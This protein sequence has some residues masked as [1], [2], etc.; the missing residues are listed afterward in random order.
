MEQ[1]KTQ[2]LNKAIHILLAEDEEL[3]R[4][5]A[6]QFFKIM[7]YNFTICKNGAEALEI[8]RKSWQNIDLVF[9][10]MIM[11]V[12]NGKDAFAAMKKINPDIVALIT[13]G[14]SMDEEAQG[15]I[16]QGVKGFIQKPFKMKELS[17][18]IIE[19]LDKWKVKT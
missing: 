5:I 8:Y 17:K 12:M 16:E 3:I 7:G 4:N 19:I 14:Y 2:K 18:K 13:S 1:L 6:T 15:I 9:L 10:D 11:P